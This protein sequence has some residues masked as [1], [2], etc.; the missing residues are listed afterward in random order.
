MTK[1]DLEQAFQQQLTLCGYEVEQEYMF[2]PTR[3]WRFDF[4]FPSVKIAAEI[5][6]GT[7]S[8]GRHTRGGGFREDCI[9]YNEAVLLGWKVYRFTGDMVESGLALEYIEKALENER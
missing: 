4:A 9:K 2:H 3:R 7:W 1:S 8:G 5:E 6:G